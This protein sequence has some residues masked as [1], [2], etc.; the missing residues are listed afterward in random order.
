M[1][2]CLHDGLKFVVAAVVAGVCCVSMLLC[3]HDGLKLKNGYDYHKG[4]FSVSML[5]CLHDGL[6]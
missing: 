6:K 4:L 1:L 5:L 2:L 3:L